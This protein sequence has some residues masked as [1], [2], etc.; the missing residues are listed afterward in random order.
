[1]HEKPLNSPETQLDAA[2]ILA[3]GAEFVEHFGIRPSPVEQPEEFLEALKQL[4]PRF[5]G[6]KNLLR[7][8]LEL[9]LDTNEWPEET[10][11]IIMKTAEKMRMLEKETPLLGHYD[12]VIALGGARASNLDRTLYAALAAHNGQASIDEIIVA[13]SARLVQDGERPATDQY[14]PGAQTE[15][16]LCD[17]AAQITGGRFPELKVEAYP[18]GDEKAGTPKVIEAVLRRLQA[19]G[20]LTEASHIGVVTTQIYQASTSLDA[21]RVAERYGVT[22]VE[23]VGNPSDPTILAARTPATYKSEIIRTLQAA[24]LAAQAGD[25]HD[26]KE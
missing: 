10:R 1:M 8:E 23:A 15:Y 14:A 11:H 3:A 26:S 9:A 22:D 6:D 12:A 13:G 18:G 4:N 2:E 24:V 7:Y 21:R 19:Q 25:Q 20:K 17:A 16:D 5:E